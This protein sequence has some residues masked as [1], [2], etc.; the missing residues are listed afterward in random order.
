MIP[1]NNIPIH[2]LG[3]KSSLLTRATAD[4]ILDKVTPTQINPAFPIVVDFRNIVA[5]APSFLDQ[6]LG[7]LKLKCSNHSYPI[8]LRFLEVPTHASEK[9][10]AIG[11]GHQMDLREASTNEWFWV[12]SG[13]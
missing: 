10:A 11:R 13:N 1:M 6:F 9:F 7:G 12:E 5:V 3:G 4:A 2:E 8:S